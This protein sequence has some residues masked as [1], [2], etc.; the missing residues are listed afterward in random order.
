[1]T[2]HP[3]LGHRRNPVGEHDRDGYTMTLIAKIENPGS[4]ILVGF[5]APQSV[6]ISNAC[7]YRILIHFKM[8]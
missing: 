4:E 8:E 3:C 5:A 6:D 1:M 2:Q 7:E